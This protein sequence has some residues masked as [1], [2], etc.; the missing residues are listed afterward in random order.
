[1]PPNNLSFVAQDVHLYGHLAH[2][3]DVVHDVMLYVPE[4]II[5]GVKTLHK[6]VRK[7]SCGLK[8]EITGVGSIYS[9]LVSMTRM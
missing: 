7:L 3:D 5:I 9:T 4:A 1:M 8:G 6:V 2:Y